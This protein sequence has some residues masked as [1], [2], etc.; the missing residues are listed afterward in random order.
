MSESTATLWRRLGHTPLT[1]LIRGRLS[2]RL[3][4]EGEIARA[5]LPP[6]LGGMVTRVARRTGLLRSE[7][8]DVAREL[9][10]HC[11]DALHAGV[12]PDAVVRTFGD[13]RTAARLI[14]RAKI[15]QRHILYRVRSWI[16]QG[17]GGLLLALTIFTAWSALRLWTGE[18][19]IARD[20]MGEYNATVLR[21]PIEDRAAPLYEKA[22]AAYRKPEPIE[23][24]DGPLLSPLYVRP[25]EP[26]WPKALVALEQNREAIALTF[27]AASRPRFGFLLSSVPE[28][29][30]WRGEAGLADR[31]TPGTPFIYAQLPSVGHLITLARLLRIKGLSA[32]ERNAPDEIVQCV[33]AL[34]GMARHSSETGVLVT[35]VAGEAIAETA[36]KLTAEAIGRSPEMLSDAQW[37]RIAHALAGYAPQPGYAIEAES[38]RQAF[39]DFLQ[40]SYTDDGAGGGQLTLAGARLIQSLYGPFVEEKGGSAADLW[41]GGLLLHAFSRR[42]EQ[43]AEYRAIMDG[44]VRESPLPFWL[45]RERVEVAVQERRMDSPWYRVRYPL[46]SMLLPALH[47]GEQRTHTAALRREAV[48]TAIGLELHRRRAGAYPESLAELTPDLMPRVPT[49]L[50]DGSPIRYLLREGKPVLYSVGT[51]GDDDGGRAAVPVGWHRPRVD[52]WVAPLDDTSGVREGLPDGDWILWPMRG[53]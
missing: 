25:E 12:L 29:E 46:I 40:R 36:R 35:R 39:E 37:K 4:W 52:Q 18:P 47:V 17:L 51:D 53:K 15:R 6:M 20:Y 14:R 5:G 34:A 44:Y 16:L 8:T 19:R 21:I 33:E 27:E 48:L 3:D 28:R 30:S 31:V 50:F 22:W 2:G 42:A 7:R 41:M 32:L 24:A 9:V 1:D 13:E 11:R 26:Y 49:D 10:A 45:R 23:R 43:S 38:E